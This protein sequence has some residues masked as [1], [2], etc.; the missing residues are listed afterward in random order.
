VTAQ[1]RSVSEFLTRNGTTLV[2][3]AGMGDLLPPDAEERRALSRRILRSFELAGYDLVTPPVFEH[4]AVVRRGN[5]LFDNRELLRFV[6]PESGEVAVLR[7][8]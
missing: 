7:P 5:E 2:A 3:P 8:E 4:A 1:T 6:E